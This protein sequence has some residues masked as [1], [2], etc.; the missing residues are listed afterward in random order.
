MPL[1]EPPAGN[2]G[3]EPAWIRV[4][5]G[6]AFGVLVLGLAAWSL[7]AAA[8]APPLGVS[9]YSGLRNVQAPESAP[10]SIVLGHAVGLACGAGSLF[11]L[12]GGALESLHTGPFTLQHALASALAVGATA[13]ATWAL[14]AIHPPALAT[15]LVASL[16]LIDTWRDAGALLAGAAVIATIAHRLR[17]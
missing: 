17:R 16:G 4:S 7:D 14:R 1:S 12:G 15:T 8:L 2:L 6:S 13:S 3:Q 11:A 5:L 9:I 10:R